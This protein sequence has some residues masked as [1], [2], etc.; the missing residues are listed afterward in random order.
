[1]LEGQGAE[2]VTALA[3]KAKHGDVIGCAT[4]AC[5]RARLRTAPIRSRERQRADAQLLMTFCLVSAANAYLVTLR[6]ILPTGTA[7]RA[8]RPCYTGCIRGCRPRHSAR[9][10]AAQ[11]RRSTPPPKGHR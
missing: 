10:A 8:A 9:K 11:P 7:R 1:L 3:D 2:R 6:A 5:L 4:T